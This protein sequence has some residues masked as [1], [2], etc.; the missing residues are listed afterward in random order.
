MK[1][2]VSAKLSQ[3]GVI[4]NN[5]LVSNS[6]PTEENWTKE[7]YAKCGKSYP[8]FY[9]MD[10]LAKLTFLT[11][12]YMEHVI[13]KFDFSD[14]GIA[15]L[16]ANASS[17]KTT[18]LKYI[19]SYEEK[20]SPSPSLFVYTLPNILTGEL[21]ILNKWYGE[22]IFFIEEKF[23]PEFYLD[24]INFYFSKGAKA[25]LSGWVESNDNNE[26]CFLFLVENKEGVLTKEE[27]NNLYK[28]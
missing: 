12:S 26:E 21:S 24:Q 13:N 4:I 22:N 19:S 17:S 5:D 7:L 28:K 9:K 1:L 6:I 2:I 27:L 20:N 14:D 11:Y 15:L 8:K 18:D 16:F 3:K 25:V 10:A 23:D